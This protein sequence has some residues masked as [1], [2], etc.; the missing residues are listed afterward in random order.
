MEDIICWWSGGVTSAVACKIAIDLFGI[1]RCRFIFID[2]KNE[3]E[4]TYVFKINCEYWYGGKIETITNADYDN[5]EEVWKKFLSLNTAHGAICSSELKRTT[6]QRFQKEN[7]YSHQVFGFEKEEKNRAKALALNYPDTKPLFPLIEKGLSKIDCVKIVTNAGIDLPNS[8]VIGYKN[9]NCF[10][11]GCVQG[12]IGYWQKMRVDFPEKFDR[13]A[14]VEHNL[15]DLKGTPVTMLKDQSRG[16]GLVFLKPHPLHPHI[17]DIS[18]MK[19]RPPKPLMDCNGFCGT[20]DLNKN[21]T[22]LELNFEPLE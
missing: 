15:T 14:K 8:Y 18:M 7:K 1:D 13:M 21:N 19:G 9:N 10:N 6:R 2:T 16:G 3:D 11:T 4:S 5:I 22:E 20:N 12:G 17:K